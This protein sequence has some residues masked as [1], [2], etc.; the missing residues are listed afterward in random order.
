[1]ALQ[2]VE[3]VLVEIEAQVGGGIP[4]VQIVGL[5]DAAVQESVHRMRSAVVNSGRKWPGVRILLALSPATLRKSGSRFDLA[6]AATVLA[7]AG[8]IEPAQL[9]DTVLIG[10][11]ALDGRIRAV[12]GVL[13]SV[14]AAREAGLRRVVVPEQAL[15]EAALV[16]EVEL[17]GAASLQEVVD[18]FAGEGA[19]AR[20]EAPPAARAPNIPELS[21]VVGQPDAR[22]ALEVAAAG[23]HHL[24][25][26]GPPG[27]GKTM[28]ARRIVGLLPELSPEEA[29][30]LASTHSAGWRPSRR[31]ITP[32]PW[33]RCWAAG[34]GC[35]GRVRSRCP[36]G[37]SCSWTSAPSSRRT[38]W[39]RC[40]H[41]WRR[42]WCGSPAP[43]G[44]SPTPPGSSWS[45]RP[46]RVPAPP[47]TTGT[48]AAPHS[49]VGAT[50]PGCRGP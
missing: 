36:I 3:G 37:G 32:R 9:A 23:G 35:L 24:L 42:A 39:T 14:L 44:T 45:W 21:E 27:T 48:A 11:L 4:G 13:P 20:P 17:F 8:V 43:T 18:W 31:R 30:Q 38:S 33:P 12:R 47:P 6:L 1:V 15:A 28:L 50:R 34:V 10:E 26:I 25:L 46:T 40:A 7:G 5:V 22:W 2:G 16:D 19:L 29:L 41:R 49:C